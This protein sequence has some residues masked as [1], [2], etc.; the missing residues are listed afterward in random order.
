[1]RKLTAILLALVLVAAAAVPALSES[2]G[3]TIG[4]IC[5]DLSQAAFQQILSGMESKAREMGAREVIA[6]DCE[7]SPE[8]CLSHLDNLIGLKV[9]ILIIC[10]PDQQLSRNIVNRC[11]EAGIPVFADSDGLIVDGK[12]VAP[13]LELDAYTVGLGQGEWL[14]NYV[15]TQT[16]PAADAGK[17]AFMRMTMNLVS[18]C[19]PRAEGARDAFLKGVPDFD[20]AR[21]IDANYDGTIEQGYDVAAATI[22][23]HPEITK[24]LVTAPNDEGAAG[25]ARALEA[26]KLDRDACVVGAGAYIAKEEFRKDFSC[27]RSAAYFSCYQAGEVEGQAAM[28]FLRDGKEIFG[29]YHDTYA[30]E[31]DTAFG[32]YPLRGIMVEP[33]NYREIM[34]SDAD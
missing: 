7:M 4:Y 23:A 28:E 31:G 13:A 24:W 14:A 9:D 17:T 25:A 6:L 33:S 11:N 34:G 1:M 5:K 21:I 22:A 26:A 18:S 3:W 10:S 29:E 19:V 32:I 12:H 16:D 2:G 20:P 15:N 8:K 30:A 27:F